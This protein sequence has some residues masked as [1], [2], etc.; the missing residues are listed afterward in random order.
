MRNKDGAHSNLL[1]TLHQSYISFRLTKARSYKV[2]YPDKKALIT[3]YPPM[4]AIIWGIFSRITSRK[5]RRVCR[6]C[7]LGFGRGSEFGFENLLRFFGLLTLIQNPTQGKFGICSVS[8]T[9][10]HS[11]RKTPYL[12]SAWRDDLTL[13]HLLISGLC[14]AYVPL[15]PSSH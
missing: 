1:F 15:Y 9:L 4:T 7:G 3:V 10:P 6:R 14:D 12:S 2:A 5:T 11:T 8:V 13:S